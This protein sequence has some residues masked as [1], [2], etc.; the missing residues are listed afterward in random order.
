MIGV[1]VDLGSEALTVW[2]IDVDTGERRAVET[3]SGLQE[4]VLCARRKGAS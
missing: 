4:G 3:A 1:I 2:I